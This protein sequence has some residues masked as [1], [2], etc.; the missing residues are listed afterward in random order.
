MEIMNNQN[1]SIQL[2]VMFWT[3]KKLNPVARFQE[4]HSLNRTMSHLVRNIVYK[5]IF[6]R[7]KFRL[8]DKL[9]L[10]QISY[11]MTFNIS[12]TST[13]IQNDSNAEKKLNDAQYIRYVL[14]ISFK[15]IHS[16]KK[17]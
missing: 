3:Q 12:G 16:F 15:P 2:Q 5:T 17:F 6:Y 14:E 7:S 9:T 8:N 10:D 11:I 13:P 1:L 4:N